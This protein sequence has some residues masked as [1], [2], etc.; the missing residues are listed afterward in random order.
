MRLN[1]STFVG[2]GENRAAE[3]EKNNKELREG[4]WMM[5]SREIYNR[6]MENI[7]RQSQEP[8]LGVKSY[9]HPY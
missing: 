3:V 6:I 4:A 7:V 8:Q 5:S 9:F 1:V 2:T